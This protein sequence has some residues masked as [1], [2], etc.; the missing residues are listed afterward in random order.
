MHG[1]GKQSKGVE[2]VYERV[3]SRLTL[4][5]RSDAV[6]N[7]LAVGWQDELVNDCPH[8]QRRDWF[9]FSNIWWLCF[10]HRAP[11][12]SCNRW[13]PFHIVYKSDPRDR[14]ICPRYSRGFLPCSCNPPINVSQYVLG[15]PPS[16]AVKLWVLANCRHED[17]QW[18]RR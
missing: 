2:R 10:C 5:G 15:D 14:Y 17:Q 16:A 12:R 9:C 4:L 13:L 8:R 7:L 1:D 3:W 18:R 11:T 6:Q